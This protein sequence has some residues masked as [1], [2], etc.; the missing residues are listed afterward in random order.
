MP[1][2]LRATCLFAF[3]LAAVLLA[4]PHAADAGSAP[5]T[6]AVTVK[7]NPIC[8]ITAGTVDF[9]VYNPLAATNLDASGT[10]TISCAKGTAYQ[11]G[12]GLGGNASGTTR[13]MTTTPAADFLT[14]ELYS[15]SARGSI[16][17]NATP[18]WVTG[19]APSKAAITL[20]VY[21]RITPGQDVGTGTYNDSV[22]STVNF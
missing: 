22:V 5:S 6:V 10:F 13:R 15:D 11:V 12:L 20:T 8:T 16:W 4:A 7:V 2:K 9:L 18:A 17:G 1:F 19:T 3:A 14:Y 21:G